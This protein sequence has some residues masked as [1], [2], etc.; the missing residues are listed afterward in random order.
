MLHADVVWHPVFTGVFSI[1][2][3][4]NL[5]FDVTPEQI[6][7][8]LLII[9]IWD[10]SVVTSPKAQISD[11]VVNLTLLELVNTGSEWVGPT[12]FSTKRR[13]RCTRTSFFV[14]D[15]L[16]TPHVQRFNNEQICSFL[17]FPVHKQVGLVGLVWCLVAQS[18]YGGNRYVR[19]IFRTFETP[20]KSPKYPPQVSVPPQKG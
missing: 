2:R 12:N 15:S 6:S 4:K 10:L 13:L 14:C 11:L 8:H 20:F 16:H 19:W 17:W 7:D 18:F 9:T 1:L 5:S 3:L